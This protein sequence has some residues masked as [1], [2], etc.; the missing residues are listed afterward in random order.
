M[1]SIKSQKN[2]TEFRLLDY[3]VFDEKNDSTKNLS[4]LCIQMFGKNEKGKTFSVKVTDF[5][6]FFY[7]KVGDSW[8]KPK[9]KS[10]R[11][12]II[13]I[14]NKL[15]LTDKY[16]KQQLGHPNIY[17]KIKKS[18]KDGDETCDEYIRN[19]IKKHYSYSVKGIDKF[20]L[21]SKH[22][23]YGFDNH[24]LYKFVK[25][26]FTNL[27][28]YNKVKNFWFDRIPDKTSQF[29]FN[30]VLKTYNYK[31]F[32]TEIYEAKLP[33]L[34]RFFHIKNINPSGW[35]KLVNDFE[36]IPYDD[37]KT[38][39]DYEYMISH[40][41]IISLRDKETIVPIK[42]CSYDIEASSS[43]GDFPLAKK[44]YKKLAGELQQ[45]WD[46]CKKDI[47]KLTNDEQKILLLNQ[48]KTAFGLSM[49]PSDGI[50]IVFPK[51]REMGSNERFIKGKF[52][53]LIT[54][55][56]R[57][58]VTRYNNKK[59]AKKNN[60][61][62]NNE[63][64][65][66]DEEDIDEEL[67]GKKYERKLFVKY[68]NNKG[69]KYY[70]IDCLLDD[71]DA[72]KKVD[73]INMA[74]TMILPKLEGDKVTFI[75]STFMIAGENKPYLNHGVCLGNCD[76][77]EMKHS[78]LEMVCC[79]DEEDVLLE[80]TE[81]IKREK[82]DVIIGYNIFG[83][84]YKFM[85]ERAEENDCENEFCSLG[86][87]STENS[88]ARHKICRRE[89]KTLKIASGSHELTYINIDGIIQID[90]YNYFRREVNLSSY[91][92]QDVASHY[93]GDIITH[94]ERVVENGDGYDCTE[95]K[96][97]MESKGDDISH[98]KN[99]SKITTRIK[100]RNLMGLE[101]D[102]F[103]IFEIIGHSLD[104]YEG[105]KKYKV[106][107]VDEKNGEF[108]V[109]G[110]IIMPPKN[111]MRWGLGKDD[112]SPADL[113]HA[114][115]EKGT[116][117]D[118][119]IIA[120]YCFQDCNLV[121][122]LM[123]KNDIFTGMSEIAAIC[124]VPIDYIIMRGQGIKLLS[125]ISKKCNEKNTLMPVLEKKNDGGY[126]GAICLPPKCGFYSDKPVAVVDYASLYPSSMISE[127]I[128]HDS[129]V[130][131]KEFDLKGNLICESGNEGFNNLP[132]YNYVDIEYDRYIYE[133]AEG[134]TKVE[135]K[136]G[137]N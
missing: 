76:D 44:E 29:G 110:D 131:T 56:L 103:V 58:L 82:P 122:D 114:F 47:N 74:L 134:K 104:A 118:R 111:K 90:L 3:K 100:S 31:G 59:N 42:I 69:K 22:K 25:L 102:N 65:I 62:D 75:G 19:N 129:K 132:G 24:S 137:R 136:K 40:E 78:D 79:E 97:D 80:W 106:L 109:E 89:E 64:K 54:T 92:L 96:M 117:A 35:V 37:K 41:N 72:A 107:N 123:R 93:I 86:K 5:K 28:S 38:I 113:F 130:T 14:L 85:L 91:K 6:P 17:P 55:E 50:S 127:N 7:V 66:N 26:S 105:G 49:C 10:F 16:K 63:T 15:D 33:P 4:T 13:E 128:S 126:E 48:I 60:I 73:L 8:N 30:N 61:S 133:A 119:T 46:K 121:H 84:D 20:E 45:Y 18:D 120:K 71:I 32:E 68:S 43:H 27:H 88:S 11:S 21:C 57:Y 12:D 101:E 87:N 98:T 23:L 112:V 99:D 39:C 51:N 115:S 81:I 116:D 94:T 83:F 70:I 77:F 9:V 1:D 95:T 124:Y 36:I 108:L 135:K 34:L 52:D 53:N 125:F 2:P 67:Y